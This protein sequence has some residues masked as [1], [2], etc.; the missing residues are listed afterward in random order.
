MPKS[1]RNS[2]AIGL[3]AV[4]AL[5]VSAGAPLRAAAQQDASIAQSCVRV[6]NIDRTKII[7]KR[8]ILFYLRD[9]TVLQNALP[10]DCPALVAPFSKL[11]YDVQGDRL[12]AG[13]LIGLFIDRGQDLLRPGALAATSACKIGM[14]LPLGDEEVVNLLA[15]AADPRHRKAAK[16]N[17][18]G[19]IKAEPVEISAPAAQSPPA[20]ETEA[21]KK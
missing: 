21:L 9:D 17:E 5:C 3:G 19:S 1:R 11:T 10:K 12:C 15:T 18:S 4:A 14:F 7:D 16:K 6:S 20:A 2:P 8:N 13:N